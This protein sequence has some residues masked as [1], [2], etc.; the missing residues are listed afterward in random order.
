MLTCWNPNNQ[1]SCFQDRSRMHETAIFERPESQSPGQHEIRPRPQTPPWWTLNQRPLKYLRLEKV[2]ILL[3]VNAS[4]NVMASMKEKCLQVALAATRR[5][6]FAACAA[7]D[8]LHL[9]PKISQ[10]GHHMLHRIIYIIILHIIYYCISL[11]LC[12]YI[13]I[14]IICDTSTVLWVAVEQ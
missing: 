7:T 5:H 12:M 2:V 8:L 10:E 3:A 13:Y 9:T 1:A 14:Y 11:S 4:L 6:P